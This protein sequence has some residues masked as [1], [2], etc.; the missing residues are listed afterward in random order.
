MDTLPTI[1]E[2]LNRKACEVLI[3]NQEQCGSGAVPLDYAGAV[4]KTVWNLCAGL[5]DDDILSI[6]AQHAD[7]IGQRSFVRN[8]ICGGKLLQL[9]WNARCDGFKLVNIDLHSGERKLMKESK[10]QVGERELLMADLVSHILRLK[11]SFEI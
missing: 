6:A 2:E 7:Q 4:S 11:N 5:I 9:Q 8:F 1:R 3:R 10:A